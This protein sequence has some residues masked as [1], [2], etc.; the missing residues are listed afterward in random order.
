[1]NKDQAQKDFVKRNLDFLTSGDFDKK[2]FR[3][4]VKETFFD[5]HKKK[6]G[7][8][9]QGEVCEWVLRSQIRA[10]IP[11]STLVEQL[12][13]FPIYKD[14]GKPKLQQLHGLIES[15]YS[16]GLDDTE[17][18]AIDKESAFE[19]VA[20]TQSAALQ[21]QI[22]EKNEQNLA[23]AETLE[24]QLQ[25]KR[26]ENKSLPSVLDAQVIEEP[27][28]VP[29][30]EESK[31]W[32]Q[33]FYLKENPFPGQDGLS[34]IS[35]SDY[36]GVVVKTP[37]YESFIGNLN[38]SI[39]FLLNSAF[40]LIGKFG[41]GKT[42][43]QDYLTYYLTQRDVL[44]ITIKCFR[45]Q[46]DCNGYLDVFTGKLIPELKRHASNANVAK[47]LTEREDIIVELCAD[48][49]S[50]RKGIVIM[51]DDFHKFGNASV[52]PIYDFLGNLQLYKDELV[53]QNC[54]VG[55]IVSAL[56]K[57]YADLNE[58]QQMSGFFDSSPIVMS[59]PTP[60][61]IQRIVNKRIATYCFDSTPRQLDINFVRH[62]F[63]KKGSSGS[64]RDYLNLILDELTKSGS[65]LVNS[66][67]D[68]DQKTLDDILNL[69][70][71]NSTVYEPM[72]KLINAS[73]FK[74]YSRE[75]VNKCL[76]ILVSLHN[77][78]GVEEDDKLFVDNTFYF[79][80]LKD[81][82]LISKQRIDQKTKRFKWVVSLSLIHI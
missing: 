45:S 38:K 79:S 37:P 56:P 67:I 65:S 4:L 14:I 69:F 6:F 81:L 64:Y 41:Y 48:I 2:T 36:E 47:D 57:W 78:E 70:K 34:K 74:K 20:A 5:K 63:E 28:F 8:P 51:L 9:K 43:F 71:K 59:D 73:G 32:W 25:Q 42:T 15:E 24:K 29:E 66:P 46:A 12:D 26:E 16:S 76:E 40:M 3:R 7:I 53:R 77:F 23:K 22:E 58:H 72:Q 10:G 11:S 49:A 55:F 80:R 18:R 21:R 35:Q 33:E 50:S 13:L 62:V 61:Y 19:A 82:R 68:I 44:P 39:D 75:Q 27:D 31:T 60:D 52:E 1:M 17:I 54:N 30:A